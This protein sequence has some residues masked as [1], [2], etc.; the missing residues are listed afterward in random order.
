MTVKELC[1]LIPEN[2]KTRLAIN[3][4]LYGFIHKDPF[5]I[6]TYGDY[7]IQAVYANDENE[8]EIELKMQLVKAHS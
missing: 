5:Q 3:G 6:T 4:N 7:E 8:I 2:H 1:N